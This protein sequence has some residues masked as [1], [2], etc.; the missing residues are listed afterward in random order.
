[1]PDHELESGDSPELEAL[2]D[3]INPSQLAPTAPATPPAPPAAPAAAPSSITPLGDSLEL[4]DLFESVASANPPPTTSVPVPAAPPAAPAASG[5]P[6]TDDSPEL[7]DLFDSIQQT[8]MSNSSTPAAEATEAADLP[9]LPENLDE[10]GK[11]MYV[12]VGHLTRRLHDALHEL[13]Y[14][15]SL[16]RAASAMIPDAKERLTY[17]VTMTANAAERALN[18]TERAQPLQDELGAQAKGLHAQWEQAFANSL[19]LEQFRQLSMDTRHY[20][21][22][23]PI[24]THA[25]S[26]ELMEIVMAQDFQDLTGQVIKKVIDMVQILEGELVGFLMEFQPE[27]KITPQPIEEEGLE[28]GPVINADG[29]TDVVTGQQQVDD[30]LESLGF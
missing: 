3:N 11:E 28:N 4:Q 12:K 9:Y 20:L 15:K 1:M 18:A 26:T 2:F 16:E 22:E 17:I 25:T 23:V 21:H 27:R 19:S 13:G 24:K 5:M 14:D 29:R 6:A 7:E 8:A 30:L 10:H